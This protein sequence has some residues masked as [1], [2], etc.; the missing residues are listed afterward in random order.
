MKSGKNLTIRSKTMFMY[1]LLYRC[2]FVS[3][4]FELNIEANSRILLL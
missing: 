4:T 3:M 1:L 2:G